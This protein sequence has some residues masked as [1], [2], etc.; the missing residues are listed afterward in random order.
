MKHLSAE[1]F[2]FKRGEFVSATLELL[3]ILI[4]PKF[5]TKQLQKRVGLLKIIFIMWNE[6]Y[7]KRK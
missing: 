6:H 7:L 2:V 1:L 5:E 3:A 4:K